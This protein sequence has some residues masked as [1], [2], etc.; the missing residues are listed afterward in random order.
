MF[1]A[2]GK[3]HTNVA[4]TETTTI[5]LVI[6]TRV[7]FRGRRLF[8]WRAGV[9]ANRTAVQYYERCPESSDGIEMRVEPGV[10]ASL[11]IDV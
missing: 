6:D 4:R 7:A 3:G 1:K 9:T 11:S 8:L 2:N 10:S 5:G